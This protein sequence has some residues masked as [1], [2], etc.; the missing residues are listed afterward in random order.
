MSTTA[1]LGAGVK[2]GYGDTAEAA[3]TLLAKVLDFSGWDIQVAD[4]KVNNHDSTDKKD[5]YIPGWISV[6]DGTV[7]IIYD[8]TAATTLNTL[9]NG[10][11]I[12]YFTLTFPDGSKL[13]SCGYLKQLGYASPLEDKMTTKLQIKSS[14]SNVTFTAAA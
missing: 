7:D 12:K 14:N 6:T 3:P 10:R 11:T 1:Q 5:E 9:I 2:F 13:Q 4:V 8:K